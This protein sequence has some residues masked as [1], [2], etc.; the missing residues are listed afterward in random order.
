MLRQLLQ[1]GGLV[2]VH[3]SSRRPEATQGLIA[4][5]LGYQGDWQHCE[6][7]TDNSRRTLGEGA[8]TSQAREFLDLAWPPR[9]EDARLVQVHSWCK[10]EDADAV[11]YPLYTVGG[12]PMKTVA[13]A[14]SR[15]GTPGA[16]L[17]LG[18]SWQAGPQEGWGAMLDRVITAFHKG[19]MP[20]AASR[21]R[22][23]RL[24]VM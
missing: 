18:Y 4:E 17:W 5:I 9:L 6:A 10:H 22:H 13:Q 8:L 23:S 2:I 7:L 21:T 11:S 24:V 14:F 20:Y 16:V 12:D 1:S 15:V 3:D 19:T